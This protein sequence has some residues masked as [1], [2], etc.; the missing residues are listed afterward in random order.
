MSKTPKTGAHAKLSSRS[1]AL[2]F[3]PKKSDGR[4]AYNSREKE[5]SLSLRKSNLKLL[6]I[7]FFFPSPPRFLFLCFIPSFFAFLSFPFLVSFSHH[8]FSSFLFLFLFHFSPFSPFSLYFSPPFRA[9][10]VWVKRRKFPPLL[11]QA[12]CVAFPFSFLFFYFIILFMTSYTTWLN[13]SHEIMP[14]IWLNVSHSF[15]AKCHT[16]EVPCGIPNPCHVSSDIPRLEKREIPTTS[17]SNEIRRGYLILRDDFNGEVRFVIRD[18][19]KFW[20]FTEITILPF[21]RKLE[22]S[23][24]LQV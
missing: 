7:F 11:P 17:E 24:V 14:P 8:F 4:I 13:L 20:I 19:E 9:L 2:L 5:D 15:Y 22:F 12:K 6:D 23:R 16:L 18:L 10:T 3:G 1:A 21:L